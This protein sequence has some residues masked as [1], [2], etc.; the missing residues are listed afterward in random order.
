MKIVRHLSENMKAKYE[1]ARSHLF[2]VRIWPESLDDKRLEWRGQLKYLPTGETLY[3][4]EWSQVQ[5]L[6]QRFVPDFTIDYS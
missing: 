3:F 2:T 5:E 6:I 1:P 4:R